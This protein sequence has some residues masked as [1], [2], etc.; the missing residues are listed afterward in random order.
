MV[1][2]DLKDGYLHVPIHPCHWG[3]LQFALRNMVE[4]L[5]V[6]QWQVLP[7][8]LAPSP[9]NMV[10]TKHQAPPVVAHLHL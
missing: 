2:L 7:C 4:D 1:S 10:L 6:S 5:L 8:G 3:Y 9:T